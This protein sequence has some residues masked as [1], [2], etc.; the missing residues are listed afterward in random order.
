MESQVNR[1]VDKVWDRYN[2]TPPGQRVSESLLPSWCWVGSEMT[3]G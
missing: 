1:L 2:Q 3:L